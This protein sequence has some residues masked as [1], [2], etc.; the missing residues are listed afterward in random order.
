[1]FD[2]YLLEFPAESTPEERALLITSIFQLD[3]AYF[4]KKGGE[5]S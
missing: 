3:Y 2:N 5:D 1:M 4:E